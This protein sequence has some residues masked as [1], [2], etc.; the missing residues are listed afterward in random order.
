MAANKKGILLLIDLSGFRGISQQLSFRCDHLGFKEEHAHHAL[1]RRTE[2]LIHLG[3]A[4]SSYEI[5]SSGTDGFYLRFTNLTEALAVAGL[6]LERSFLDLVNGVAVLKPVIALTE[7]DFTFNDGNP[8]GPDLISLLEA[9]GTKPVTPFSLWISERVKLDQKLP[10]SFIGCDQSENIETNSKVKYGR[11]MFSPAGITHALP[12]LR[13]HGLTENLSLQD[14]LVAED[15]HK[16]FDL[17]R[18]L[19]NEANVS[20]R[21]VGG[22]PPTSSILFRDYGQCQLSLLKDKQKINGFQ[23]QRIAFCYDDEPLRTFYWLHFNARV[24]KQFRKTYQFHIIRI[25]SGMPKPV[26]FHIIDDRY[27]FLGLRAYNAHYSTPTLKRCIC[28]ES[29]SVASA[30]LDVFSEYWRNAEMLTPEQLISKA[31]N[32]KGLTPQ[33]K[34]DALEDI[35]KLFLKE[36]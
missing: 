5:I 12:F 33:I 28:W 2:Q 11:Y 18:N 17:L 19:Q 15:E 20:I 32:M 36:N 25:P 27:T 10:S 13:L 8:V 23:F 4:T 6:I 26:A 3:T 9:C 29:R 22:G 14:S 21:V 31:K 7:G 35:E 34:Q 1:R 16:A 24:M 30:F